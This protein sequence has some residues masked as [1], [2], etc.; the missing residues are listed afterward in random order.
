MHFIILDLEATCWQGNAMAREPEII[1]L[2]AYRVNGYGEWIDHFQSFVKPVLHPRLSSYCTDLTGIQQEQV[3]KARPFNMVFPVFED[4]FYK[5]DQPHIMCTWGAK[6]MEIISADCKRHDLD[7]SFLPI[8][9][10]L[11][12]QFAK[13]MRF[14]KEVGLLK[15][16]DYAEIEFEG[17]HHRALDDAYNTTRLFLRYLDHWAY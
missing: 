12:A 13:A 4:W 1:E 10:N 17:Q 6:D 9:I 16:L 2:A 3:N 5:I 14:P 7:E 8:C 11:K 15:A